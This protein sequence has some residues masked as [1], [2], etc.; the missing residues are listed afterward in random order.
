MR[1]FCIIRVSDIVF[2]FVN[3]LCW[4]VTDTKTKN[5]AAGHV[6][7]GPYKPRTGHTCCTGHCMNHAPALLAAPAL[8]YSTHRVL[9]VWIIITFAVIL[10]TSDGPTNYRNPR[11]PRWGKKRLKTSMHVDS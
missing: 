3:H 7:S 6:P 8:I 10:N 9:V 2:I 11:N 5:N 4:L 1:F